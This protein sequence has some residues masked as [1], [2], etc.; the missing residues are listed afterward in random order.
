[1]FL[2]DA[3]HFIGLV[4]GKAVAN[5]MEHADIVTATTHKALRGPGAG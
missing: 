4:A 2:V 1:V 3:A 5:P